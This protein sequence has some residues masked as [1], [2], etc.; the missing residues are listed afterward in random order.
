MGAGGSPVMGFVFLE[1]ETRDLALLPLGHV[2]HTKEAAICNTEK[3]LSPEP[4][5]GDTPILDFLASRPKEINVCC[6]SPLVYDIL[7]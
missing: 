4:N 5:Y 7:L 1:E 3:E 2:R 6:L